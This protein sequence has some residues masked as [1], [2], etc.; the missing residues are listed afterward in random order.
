MTK[1]VEVG[2]EFP[3]KVVKTTTFGAFVELAKGTDGL[4][5]ISN[6]SPGQRRRRRSRRSST[7]ATRSPSAWSRSTASAAASACASPRT[8]RSPARPSR[9]WP[10]SAP[11]AAAAAAA[12]AA[13]ARDGRG[14]GGDRGGRGGGR[15]RDRGAPW[16]RRDRP[17]ARPRPG[18]RLDRDR[19]LPDHRITELR[20]AGCGS[21]RRPCPPCG[22]RPWASSWAPARAARREAE[23]GLSHFLEHLLFRGTDRYGVGRDR[24]AVRR[25]GRRAQRRHR[26]GEHHGLRADARPAPAARRS[27]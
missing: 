12:T 15:D 16:R 25:H 18:P 10:A 8:R 23:A 13:R 17:R 3:G 6:V 19:P 5:H 2:D 7:R 1:E 9:S 24:P 11:A 4:L 27:T 22:P 21:S 20:L 26:Q 14:G